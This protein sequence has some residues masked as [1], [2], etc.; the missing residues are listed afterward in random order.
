MSGENVDKPVITVGP[1]GKSDWAPPFDFIVTNPEGQTFVGDYK[2]GGSYA[3]LASKYPNWKSCTGYE[4]GDVVRAVHTPKVARWRRFLAYFGVTRF[5]P[6][7]V[8]VDFECRSG[9][10][11][12]YP[13]EPD[14]RPWQRY[15]FP[16]HPI[17][18]S[19]P[20]P[21]DADASIRQSENLPIVCH[22]AE[23]RLHR[24]GVHSTRI[25]EMDMREVEER[26]LA[27]MADKTTNTDLR[28]VGT[29]TV[30]GR[31]PDAQNVPKM[32]KLNACGEHY[33]VE[34][35]E[36]KLYATVDSDGRADALYAYGGASYR[37]RDFEQSLTRDEWDSINDQITTDREWE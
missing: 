31:L 12:R 11:F 27:M 9:V 7:P 22:Q 32:Q 10:E 19:E 17:F 33:P 20:A 14:P 1:D 3:E 34:V 36:T 21:F 5:I 2:I 8:L 30:T 18:L 4:R 13:Q 26:L 16:N 29:G 15:A 23:S 35:R 25:V 37:L 28:I 24:P 6:A